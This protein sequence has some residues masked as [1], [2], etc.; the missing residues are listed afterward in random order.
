MVVSHWLQVVISTLLLGL[1][2]IFLPSLKCRKSYVKSTLPCAKSSVSLLLAGYQLRQVIVCEASPSELA[3]YLRR[4]FLIYLHIP[5]SAFSGD[6]NRT[7]VPW[8]EF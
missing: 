5:D 2:G 8:K 6:L 3:N 4:V 1:Q 7:H